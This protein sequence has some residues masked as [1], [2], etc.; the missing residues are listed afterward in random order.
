MKLKFSPLSETVQ[1]TESD[2]TRRQSHGLFALLANHDVITA[3]TSGG[4][5]DLLGKDCVPTESVD[6]LLACIHE[7]RQ[8]LDYMEL[9][10]EAAAAAEAVLTELERDLCRYQ[11]DTYRIQYEEA[12]AQLEAQQAA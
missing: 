7:A 6:Y 1:Q 4:E 9:D 8:Q 5:E 12:A 2:C 3:I 10:K 11:S